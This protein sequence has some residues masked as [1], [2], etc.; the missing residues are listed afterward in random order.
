MH[1]FRVLLARWL[2]VRGVHLPGSSQS[3]VMVGSLPASAGDR[4]A[5][6]ALTALSSCQWTN[7]QSRADQMDSHWFARPDRCDEEVNRMADTDRFIQIAVGAQVLYAL[8]ATG[9]VWH[10][11][12]GAPQWTRIP[13]Q[14]NLPPPA[15]GAVR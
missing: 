7:A 14:R 12:S 6:P 10:L 1:H 2:H 15:V 13:S 9:Q 3:V 8:D 5:R 4:G 11:P